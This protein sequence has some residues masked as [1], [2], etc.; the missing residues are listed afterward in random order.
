M[1]INIISKY[2]S[3]AGA[4]IAAL[5]LH[6]SF[7]NYKKELKISS[8]MRVAFKFANV[9]NVEEDMSYFSK[10]RIILNNKIERVLQ[11]LQ[12]SKNSN[13]HSLAFM[14]TNLH[15]EINKSSFDII[16]L[17]W[18]QGGMISIEQIAKIKKPIIWTL[19]DTWAFCGAE[20]YPNTL[21][22]RRYIEGYRK[23]NM[24]T[25]DKGLDLDR[26]CWQRKLKNWIN[27]I[28]I[29][30]PSNWLADNARKSLLMRN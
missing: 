13:L 5:R 15:N 23:N 29:V 26:W 14:P 12:I 2:D 28:Q 10:K 4:A 3:K 8:A 18:I 6:K 22:D 21:E 25:F 30:C 17:H 16:N 1:K 7:E 9:S 11:K 20:H 27:P 19:H 24:N